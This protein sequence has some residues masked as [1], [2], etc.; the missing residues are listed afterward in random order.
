MFARGRWAS[1]LTML[2]NVD[3]VFDHSACSRSCEGAD[4]SPGETL[5]CGL[6]LIEGD[7]DGVIVGTG[8]DEDS[9]VF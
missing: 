3:I 6:G 2:D 8:N 7:I 9:G 1:D 5:T 4:F